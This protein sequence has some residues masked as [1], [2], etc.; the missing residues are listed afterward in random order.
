VIALVQGLA[1]TVKLPI[2]TCTSCAISRLERFSGG[3]SSS[4]V[5]DEAR[6]GRNKREGEEDSWEDTEPGR[7]LHDAFD[8]LIGVGKSKV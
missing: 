8:W 1:I 5:V 4:E 2:L 3:I 7:E 6:P